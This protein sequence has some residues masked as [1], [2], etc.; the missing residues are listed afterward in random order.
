MSMVLGTIYGYYHPGARNKSQ[1]IV[2]LICVFMKV[3]I[4]V[5]SQGY[6]SLNVRIGKGKAK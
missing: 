2:H 4:G 5:S 3:H 1:D 6:K